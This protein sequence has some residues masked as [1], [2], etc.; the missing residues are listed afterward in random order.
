[1]PGDVG[2]LA[3]GGVEGGGRA[4]LVGIPAVPAGVKDRGEEEKAKGPREEGEGAGESETFHERAS[5]FE[6]IEGIVGRE[7]PSGSSGGE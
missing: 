4:G 1:M 5:R 7:V 2:L 3:V 6:V